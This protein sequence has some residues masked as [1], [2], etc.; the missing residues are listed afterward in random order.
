[1]E[2]AVAAG[3]TYIH[4][5]ILPQVIL[6]NDP[7]REDAFFTKVVR[8][9]AFEFGKSIIELPPDAP[10]NLLWLTRLDSGSLAGKL[11]TTL[12]YAFSY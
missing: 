4:A 10:E 12:I 3:M 5:F 9:K 6:T 2:L 1:M 8:G 11:Y 7:G